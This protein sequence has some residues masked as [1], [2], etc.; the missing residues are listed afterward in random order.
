MAATKQ[1]SHGATGVL[2][3]P[4]REYRAPR[5]E[6]FSAEDMSERIGPARAGSDA[7]D[8]DDFFYGG[9]RPWYSPR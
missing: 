2:E 5:I 6:S 9:H 7:S 8:R 3:R 4:H 1:Q